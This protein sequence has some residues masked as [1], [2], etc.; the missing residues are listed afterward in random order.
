MA[1][2]ILAFV[3]IVFALAARRGRESAEMEPHVPRSPGPSPPPFAIAL[4]PPSASEVQEGLRRAF[5]DTVRTG[6]PP[7]Y[8]VGDFNGDGAEDLAVP[9]SPVEGRLGDLNDSLANWNVQDALEVPP[10]RSGP[11]PRASPVPVTVQPNDVLLAVVHG[12]GGRGWRD[13]QAR[14]CYLVR[15]ATGAPL[16]AQ[17]RTVLLRYLQKAPK[18]P[19]DARLGGDVILASAG[20]KAGFVYWTGVRYVWHPLPKHGPASPS[21]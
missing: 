2:V 16:E 6:P 8:L 12:Y 7:R 11:A 4:P 20:K 14:Q 5:G 21:P 3:A 15:H 9:V 13:G 1:G 10:P 18:A 19:D 17:P